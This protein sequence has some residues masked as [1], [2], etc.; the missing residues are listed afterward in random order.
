MMPRALVA[1]LLTAATAVAHAQAPREVHGS[2][3]A[4]A[5]PDVGLAWAVL[6]G[7]SEAATMVVMRIAA[8]PVKYPWIA[9]AGVDPFTKA[10]QPLQ[11]AMQVVRAIDVRVARSRYAELPRTEIRLFGSA[12]A[13]QAGTPRL[14][15]FYLGVPD[16]TPEFADAAKLDA[17]LADRIARARAEM[18]KEKR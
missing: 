8:D 16:T 12:A 10:E 7:T 17:Y 15:I 4:Y 2:G 14:T 6:R 3:D 5:D 9:V 13:A 18:A 1:G 11:P